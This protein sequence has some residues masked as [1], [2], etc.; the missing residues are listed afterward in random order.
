MTP[1]N[2]GLNA[3]PPN[4]LPLAFGPSHLEPSPA[5][6]LLF[7]NC[8]DIPGQWFSKAET[9]SLLHRSSPD[10]SGAF[11]FTHCFGEADSKLDPDVLMNIQAEAAETYRELAGG[12]ALN[13]PVNFLLTRED[14]SALP[15]WILADSLDGPPDVSWM[16][17][18]GRPRFLPALRDDDE[19]VARRVAPADLQHPDIP[20]LLERANFMADFLFD[21]MEDASQATRLIQPDESSLPYQEQA[22]AW[23]SLLSLIEPFRVVFVVMDKRVPRGRQP[24]SLCEQFRTKPFIPLAGCNLWQKSEIS[25]LVNHTANDKGRNL[26]SFHSKEIHSINDLPN[27]WNKMR[28]DFSRLSDKGVILGFELD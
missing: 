23:V 13:H 24:S 26:V 2:E 10:A 19:L 14:T 8:L 4:C 12:M 28:L 22:A 3:R 11:T 15:P 16:L 27:T 20:E 1:E 6:R 17:H 5:H 25:G 7:S 21:R 18:T 9:G